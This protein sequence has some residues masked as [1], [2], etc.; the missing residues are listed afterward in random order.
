MSLIPKVRYTTEQFPKPTTSNTLMKKGISFLMIFNNWFMVSVLLLNMDAR[1][2]E[3]KL[4]AE[5][6]HEATEAR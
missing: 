5:C 3:K 1:K 6:I 2:E 4:I